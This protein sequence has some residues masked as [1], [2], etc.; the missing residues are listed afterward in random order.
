MK[1]TYAHGGGGWGGGRDYQKHENENLMGVIWK[2]VGG[3]RSTI[4]KKMRY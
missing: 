4:A 1:N 2:Y 3:G